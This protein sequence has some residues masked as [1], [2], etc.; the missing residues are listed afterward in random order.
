MKSIVLYWINYYFC[1]Q[2]YFLVSYVCFNKLYFVLLIRMFMLVH[3]K[4]NVYI[5]IQE[6]TVLL[7]L[8][9]C[10]MISNMY[11]SHTVNHRL[12][13]FWRTP[14][15]VSLQN[16]YTTRCCAYDRHIYIN[17]SDRTF[18][19]PKRR[20]MPTTRR[21]NK[22]AH[23]VFLSDFQHKEWRSSYVCFDRYWDKENQN[24]TNVLK[25][26]SDVHLYLPLA[27]CSCN[28]M[29]QYCLFFYHNIMI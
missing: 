23:L 21:R 2:F 15:C 17:L 25:W 26:C 20:Q 24:K 12:R 9:R 3:T 5:R 22:F 8:C 29:Q 6:V 7:V 13:A 10:A 28:A 11:A 14:R 4:T 27:F 18:D 16:V 1:D 19:P